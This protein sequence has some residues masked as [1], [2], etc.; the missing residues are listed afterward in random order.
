MTVNRSA[1]DPLAAL[2]VAAASQSNQ[3]AF[4]PESKVL[5]IPGRANDSVVSRLEQ[6]ARADPS[7][8]LIVA[9]PMQC[10]GGLLETKRGR[11]CANWARTWPA[12][13]NRVNPDLVLLYTD[14][15]QGESLGQLSGLIASQQA[16]FAVRTLAPA[17]DLLTA[18]GAH[19]L[20][21]SSG[22]NLA[23]GLQRATLP[24]YQ[25]MATLK[26]QRTDLFT[27]IGTE[28]PD[29]ATVSHEQFVSRS[30]S[31]LLSDAALYER[32]QGGN[33]SRVLFVGDS[34]S[35][36]LGY[37]FDRWAAQKKSAIVWNRAVEGCGVVADGDIRSFGSATTSTTP[38][39]DA[40]SEF[41]HD[42]TTFKP[43]VVV[44]LS[45]LADIQDR[46]PPGSSKFV[47]M[48]TPTF[49]DF[50]VTEYEH[51]VDTLSA[52]G[53]HVVWMTAPCLDLKPTPGGSSAAILKNEQSGIAHL[54]STIL[55]ALAKERPGKVSLFDL[56]AVMCPDGKPL[57]SVPGVA[58]MRPD[59]IHFA[60]DGSLWFAETYGDKVLKLG[61]R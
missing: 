42:V 32:R 23:V 22:G 4:A 60:V 44:V 28:L 8:S 33:L 41:P 47:S 13:I 12:L 10:S 20:W 9:P 56:A 24:F 31:V 46:R 61:G 2:N 37:G 21:S 58:D 52:Q 1:Y 18:R 6:D 30:A 54:D 11:T 40:V 17:L 35:L 3:P 19:V 26:A 14:N 38:C 49:D 36:T 34:Q 27:V 16:G 50:L 59:G 45:S 55:R 29:P 39:R 7:V 5:V 51:T 53:A 43:D 15:W 57:K 25:A 48:G